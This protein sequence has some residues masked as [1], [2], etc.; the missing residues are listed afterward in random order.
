MFSYPQYL[1]LI[2]LIAA[3]AVYIVLMTPKLNI[4]LGVFL[5]VSSCLTAM[6]I[7]VRV[8]YFR[9]IWGDIGMV[10]SILYCMGIAAHLFS[11]KRYVS[12]V[13]GNGKKPKPILIEKDDQNDKGEN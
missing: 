2:A 7:I 10:I 3:A 1:M 8:F 6:F 4:K 12:E 13:L 9:S 11:G 5:A